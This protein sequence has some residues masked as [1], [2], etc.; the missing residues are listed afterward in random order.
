MKKVFVN[1]SPGAYQC[2]SVVILQVANRRGRQGVVA[3]VRRAC[4]QIC[5]L[6]WQISG[7]LPTSQC[8]FLSP[9][10]KQGFE[11]G[12]RLEVFGATGRPF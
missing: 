8:L 4:L 10:F 9:L 6:D 2:E 7:R 1:Y 11:F 12:N 3:D 5:L